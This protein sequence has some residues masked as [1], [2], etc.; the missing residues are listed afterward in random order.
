MNFNFDNMNNLNEQ[1]EQDD[2]NPK[3]ITVDEKLGTE[4][5]SNNSD[6]KTN[7]NQELNL[8]EM[9]NEEIYPEMENE[10]DTKQESNPA[11]MT[12]EEFEDG[13]NARLEKWDKEENKEQIIGEEKD[14]IE[15]ELGNRIMVENPEFIDQKNIREILKSHDELRNLQNELKE[16]VKKSIEGRRAASKEMQDQLDLNVDISQLNISDQ[17]KVETARSEFLKTTKNV[18]SVKEIDYLLE[19]G[20]ESG[21]LGDLSNT[22][23]ERKIEM[24][25]LQ[26]IIKAIE[27][28]KEFME[29]FE[30]LTEEEREEAREEVGKFVKWL[31]WV[32]EN[33]ED[34]FLALVAM[35]MIAGAAALVM[36]VGLPAGMSAPAFLTAK[37]LVI[38]G[39][40]LVAS[41][42]GLYLYKKEKI[43]ATAKAVGIA[44]ALPIVGGAMILESILSSEK[45]NKWM[46]TLCGTSLPSWAQDKKEKS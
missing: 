42:A 25:E 37:N 18:L 38:A 13:K 32:K 3:E 28:Y 20:S 44:V 45:I 9:K 8:D 21:D 34:L 11:E 24:E 33:K 2:S 41:G 14:R 46:E 39:G 15:R 1:P 30:K 23:E 26:E 35:G 16:E 19:I 40:V 10:S 4:E 43:Q 29:K 31:E 7:T 27:K 6:V 17:M 22:H 5:G 12:E 36:S